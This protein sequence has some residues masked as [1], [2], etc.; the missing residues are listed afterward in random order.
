MT[1]NSSTQPSAPI[2]GEPL[3][4]NVPRAGMFEIDFSAEDYYYP[5]AAHRPIFKW[6]RVKNNGW[7]GEDDIVVSVF[8]EATG[9]QA[10]IHPVMVAYPPVPTGAT[11]SVETLTIRPNFN[12]LAQLEE[13]LIGNLVVQV[14]INEVV[15]AEKRNRIEFFAYN[16][17]MHND[18]DFDCLSAF[19]F[20]NHPIV[21]EIMDGVRRRLKENTGDGST[22]GYQPFFSEGPQAGINRNREVLRAIYE[23]LQSLDLEYSN[24]PQTFEG[25]GQKI[26]TPDVANRD[27]VVTCLDSTVLAASCIAAAGLD[28]L[29]F[30]VKQHAFPGVWST[31]A[32]SID[33][34]G[35]PASLW[36][37]PAVVKNINDFQSLA[38]TGL[39]LSIESTKLCR[40]LKTTF[41]MAE[42]RHLDFSK[43]STANEF[44]GIIDVVRS[45]EL[46]VRR[47]PNRQL[48]PD[49]QIYSVEIDRSAFDASIAERE[50][51][52]PES[53][54][55]DEVREKLSADNVPR[56][57]RR[58]MDALLDISNRNPLINLRTNPAF[59]LRPGEKATRGINLPMD[60]GMLAVLE[61]KL[62]AGENLRAVCAHHLPSHV[63]QDP[64]PENVLSCFETSGVFSLGPA[65]S[66]NAIIAATQKEY[67]K[68]GVVVRK[69]GKPV[70]ENGQPVLGPVSS[71]Q[72]LNQAQ[73]DFQELH[74][75]DA[76]RRFR[77]LKKIA[78]SVEADS[79]TNQLFLTIG[80]M[81]WNSPGEKGKPTEVRSPLFVVP[82][83]ISGS[84]A[85]GFRISLDSG[86]EITPNY[87]LV[88]KLRSE[89][90]LR[91]PELETP[92]LDES[93]IDVARTIATIR[94]QLSESRY[95]TI[96]VDE[97]AQIA[98]LDFATFRMWK[99]V[100]TNWQLFTK[101]PVVNHLINDSNET[102][103][104]TVT[105]FTGDALTPFS[106]DESQMQAVV[107]A[108]EGR[109]FVL[110]GPPGTGKSQ[111]IANLIAA[112][113]A[114]GKRIL[115]VAEKQVALEAVSSKLVDIGLDP[116]CITMHHESTTPESIREQLR[117][118]LDFE[119]Q[120][121]SHQWQSDSL[122]VRSLNDRLAKY[123]D[124]MVEQNALELNAIKAQS[125]VLRLGE[126]KMLDIDP[127]SFPLMGQYQT[128]IESA[129]LQIFSIVGSLFFES[130]SHWELSTVTSMETFDRNLFAR[131]VSQIRD[132]MEEHKRLKP[133]LEAVLEND[134]LTD[135]P[136]AFIDAINL[137]ADGKHLGVD[138]AQTV[139]A[140]EWATGIDNLIGQ[141]NSCKTMNS[142]VLSF[143]DASAF[144]IDLS[145]QMAAA[146]KAI[147][148]GIFKR[149]RKAEVLRTL[150][151]PIAKASV[152]KEPSELLTLLQKV[153]PV[154]SQLD[155][156]TTSLR[157]V[158]HLVIRPDFDPFLAEHLDEVQSTVRDLQLR[159]Q[160]L[161]ANEALPVRTLVMQGE[162]L[163]R[164]DVQ[165]VELM[166][167][168]WGHVKGILI[169]TSESLM[170]WRQGRSVWDSLTN[171]VPVW[172]ESSPQYSF[173]SKLSLIRHTLV[174]LYQGGLSD[175]ANRILSGEQ[176]LDDIHGQFVRGRAFTARQERLSAGVLGTFDSNSFDLAL[177]QFTRQEASRR[178]LMWKVI[179]RQLSEARPFQP[180]FRTG[181]IGKL[182][183]E[184]Q[185]KVKRVSISQLIKNYGEVITHLTPCFLMSP[186]AVSRLLPAESQYFDIVVFDEASQIR[187]AAAIP[188]MGRA[189][190]AIIVGDSQQMPPSKK[191]GQRQS[192]IEN[193]ADLG[194]E[195]LSQDLESILSECTESNVP[196]LMLK[197]HFRSQHEGLIAFSNRNYY[198]NSLVTFPAPNT[199]KTTPISWFDVPDGQFL[200]SLAG[201]GTNPAEAKAI[202][203]E[204]IRRLEDP[205]HSSKSIGVVTFNE[206]QAD[207]II[208]LLEGEMTSHPALSR[209]MTD[210]KKKERLFVVP[211]ER[212]QGDERDTI[213]LSVS[214][215]YQNEKRNVVSPTWGPLTHD[216]GEK[217]LNVAI[218]RAK[219]DLL[220][221]C[222][223]DPNHVSSD[224]SKHKGVGHTKAFLIECRE[225]AQSNGVALRAREASSLDYH[226]RT[227]H[228]LLR[229]EGIQVRENVGLSKFRIDLAVTEQ[230][231]NSQFL[232]LL[233]DGEGWTQRSTSFDRDV[234]PNSVLRLIGWRRIGRVWL[235]DVVENP[236]AVVATVQNEIAREQSRHQLIELLEANGYETRSDARLS[237]VGVDIAIR[238]A[239]Q[240]LWP[241]AISLNGPGL[242]RQ[243]FLYEGDVPPEQMLLEAQCVESLSLWMPDMVQSVEDS[244]DK[245]NFAFQRASDVMLQMAS[246]VEM[247]PRTP[248][249]VDEMLKQEES[250]AES[251]PKLLQSQMR[252]DFVD[253]RS[254][255]VVGVQQDLGPGPKENLGLVLR[256]AMEIVEMEG[257]IKEERLA[258]VLV[259]RFG[260]SAVKTSRMD[261]LRTLFARFPQSKSPFGTTYWS[262]TREHDLWRGFR[263][264]V[265][266]AART[267]DEVPAEEIVNT[268][269]AAVDLGGSCF[270]EEI[271]RLTAEVFG[272]KA[273][274]QALNAQLVPVLDWAVQQGK[275]VVEADLYKLPN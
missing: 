44:E 197:C 104:Q 209:A 181:E 159:A 93:G 101:N 96:R 168:S 80:T 86:G 201:K 15:V 8:S 83:R 259:A 76:T 39:I 213:I 43:G 193:N 33:E 210:P 250:L 77:T 6:I 245:I 34:D 200:R 157:S 217:R 49:S 128:E 145:P 185:K 48:L 18:Y 5:A 155:Q 127:E 251:G 131:V 82:V 199:D 51:E 122:V 257:P 110:E 158:P 242:F 161:A 156:L 275:L 164:S 219:Q 216:G 117:L 74:E 95:S 165:I 21:V 115:F 92:D 11:I 187:V 87:C 120:D 262:T 3:V 14:R 67:E 146:S 52:V 194:D 223:F 274:T 260:M 84:A 171:S 142:D 31:P 10:L 64:S 198:K 35:R 224:G 236:Q 170:K 148:A 57:V 20:P 261:S 215:S 237:Q 118:S 214:Y 195:E 234:L 266:E 62:M 269:V 174:P 177:A 222:S 162:V 100:Q 85:N 102:M 239:G 12:E 75:A 24:P 220:V 143:F 150:V 79:A 137:V 254:L 89:L 45:A 42:N 163:H 132:V 243:F 238:E 112:C 151:K 91:I 81:V 38:S 258:K 29:L 50:Y 173:L 207:H 182:E 179:P 71:T 22:S 113:L 27:R 114:E 244:L 69:N 268:M 68:N 99:D 190:A 59:F 138:V 188:A 230:K 246:E 267:I 37:R 235:K 36:H 134:V 94:R 19:V 256:A 2:P 41:E 191:I 53:S 192:S 133:I 186:E 231:N 255:P 208:E 88:E 46:G 221:F 30:L 149:S 218:T 248:L 227:L 105:P 7:S 144:R 108:L 153:L 136:R 204:I 240:T 270:K 26:R 203:T 189:K 16:Q 196:D 116:F 17:W 23:E 125:E 56:R 263:T 271:I 202:V 98:V 226:R 154:R 13:S 55:D 166:L 229:K 126:G 233:L 111:T 205:L 211:L 124:A 32:N 73:N 58:W 129:L 140:P 107:W 265:G 103:V 247:T 106:C 63:I 54:N 130:D 90:G 175:V 119:S 264:S 47:L 66:V 60:L 4:A 249:T 65:S 147:S 253:S 212:V 28:P 97:E 272:R 139:L 172:M 169:A 225:A 252:M 176:S 178:E 121:V 241:L 152:E 141:I 180:R 72:A 135:I 109:S 183:K 1:D 167:A 206:N 184:L 160:I 61:N 25:F 78:D 123:R 228:D 273:V 40:S 9:A 232:S 70:F